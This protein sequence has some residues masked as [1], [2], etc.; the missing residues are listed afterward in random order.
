MAI[1]P[2]LPYT[3][4][5]GQIADGGQVMSDLNTIANG[6]NANAAH[7]GA[8]N[9]ITSLSGLTTPL[10]GAQGGTGMTT[11]TAG[12]IITGNGASGFQDSGIQI[13]ALAFPP[14][15]GADYYGGSAP[16]GWLFCDGSAVSRATYSALF[17]VIGVTYGAGNGTTTFNLPDRRGRVAAGYDAGNA[18]GRLTGSTVQGVSASTLGNAGGEQAHTQASGE[19]ATHSHGVTDP[20]H[21]HGRGFAADVA[22]PE[23]GPAYGASNPGQVTL[24]AATGISIDNAG[25]STPFNVVQPTLICNCIIKT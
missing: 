17:A 6:V 7:N 8:N 5:D 3:L 10:S 4:V 14:G 2:G 9:D 12:D 1:V 15:F 22:V 25:S 18:S 24:A 19:L 16:A 21:D 23:V 11:N 13:S 20:Q